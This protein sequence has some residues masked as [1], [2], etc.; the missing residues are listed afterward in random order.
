MKSAEEGEVGGSAEK[1]KM[2]RSSRLKRDERRGWEG[3]G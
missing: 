3:G 1:L 2:M